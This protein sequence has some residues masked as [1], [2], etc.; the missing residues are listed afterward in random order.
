MPGEMIRSE[1]P[2]PNRIEKNVHALKIS[3]EAIAGMDETEWREEF[4]K[5]R[6]EIDAA[7]SERDLRTIETDLRASLKDSTNLD[8]ELRAA[9]ARGVRRLILTAIASAGVAAEQFAS[10][11]FG[12]ELFAAALTGFVVLTARDLHSSYKLYQFRNSEEGPARLRELSALVRD[13]AMRIDDKTRNTIS[14]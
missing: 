8:A 11:P 12:N 6:T 13:V 4:Q 2:Q 7:L 5:F 1:P 10:F 3:M 14:G 9:G